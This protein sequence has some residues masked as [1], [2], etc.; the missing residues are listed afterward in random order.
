MTYTYLKHDNIND[1]SAV[2]LSGRVATFDFNN[3]IQADNAPGKDVGSTWNERLGEADY[4]GHANPK[5]VVE[6]I[7]PSGLTTNTIGSMLMT[8]SQFQ[9]YCTFGSPLVFYDEEHMWNPAGS[10]LVLPKSLKIT[11]AERDDMKRYNLVLVETKE[12]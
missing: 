2:D 1:G 7:I 5:W 8:G 3:M 12:W 10:A 4:M 11:R 9:T 6:G